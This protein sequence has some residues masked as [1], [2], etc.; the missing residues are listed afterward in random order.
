MEGLR[1]RALRAAE[2]IGAAILVVFLLSSLASPVCL[3][4]SLSVY[5]SVSLFLAP[6][7]SPSLSSVCLVARNWMLNRDRSFRF[8][9]SR[10]PSFVAVVVVHQRLRRRRPHKLK[11]KAQASPARRGEEGWGG[12]RR[13]KKGGKPWHRTDSGSVREFPRGVTLYNYLPLSTTQNND[14]IGS[15]K[16]FAAS[17][18]SILGQAGCMCFAW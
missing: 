3:L 9:A 10:A 18:P 11:A 5:V 6:I 12:R 13:V 7:L 14:I 16:C 2:A 15:R 17:H 1:T 8:R 4:L